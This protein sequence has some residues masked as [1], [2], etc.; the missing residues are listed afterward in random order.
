MRS[1]VLHRFGG[2]SSGNIAIIFG[3]SLP[4]F[5]L[6]AG[7]SM[8]YA[9]IANA[10]TKMLAA[11][12][13]A[14]LAAVTPAMLAQS[15]SAAQTVAENTFSAEMSLVSGFVSPPVPTVTFSTDPNNAT[16]RI[17][18]ITATGTLNNMIAGMIGMPTSPISATSTAEGA[19]APNINF[20]VLADSSQSMAI[21]ATTAGITTLENA[22]PGQWGS[23][24]GCAFACHEAD[25]EWE[26]AKKGPYSN[27]YYNPSNASAS[28]TGTT[29][30]G[31]TTYPNGCVEMDDYALAR[32]LNVTL[33]IDNLVAAIQT[34]ASTQQSTSARNGA[35]YQMGL[36]SF[37]STFHS[38]TNG[39]TTPAAAS[40]ASSNIQIEETYHS[41]LTMSQ[42]KTN[43]SDTY[44]DAALTQINSIIPT[45][46]N[47]TNL[48][49]DTPKAF[50][51][52]IT[53][54]VEDEDRDGGDSSYIG[55]IS[56]AQ[57]TAMINRGV[58]IGV[59]YT[60][61]FP[62]PTYFPYQDYVEPI[63]S[64]IGPNLQNCASSPNYYI[65]VSTN[66]DIGAALNTIFD[67]FAVHSHLTN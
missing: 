60:T 48:A 47:G 37:D 38:Y 65:E 64:Q 49:G 6:A 62:V 4:V 15:N 18:T 24:P 55:L 53:D 56:T 34:L 13:A 33:R 51:F 16:M 29:S 58:N 54:G 27:P 46:G 17:I 19:N 36:Y 39:L 67:A 41:G 28:C 32:S 35:T 11:V 5:F 23:N 25:P 50:L 21:A 10:H 66:G 44:A 2:E 26:T 63:Q 52:L 40:T 45:P 31:N 42:Q 59:V 43:D 30:H 20:Y 14:T 22:T 12:D 61:Y 1:P 8:D 57:C 7:L 3:L 9:R